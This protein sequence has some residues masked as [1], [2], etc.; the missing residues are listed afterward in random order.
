MKYALHVMG[1][2][3]QQEVNLALIWSDGEGLV[4]C[5]RAYRNPAEKRTSLVADPDE[6]V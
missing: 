4:L 6:F 2:A 5:L 1:I 3:A